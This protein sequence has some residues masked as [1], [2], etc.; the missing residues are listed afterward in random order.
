[1]DRYL[2]QLHAVDN[3]VIS[4]LGF[5]AVK[6]S[7]HYRFYRKGIIAVFL[8]LC[9]HILFHRVFCSQMYRRSSKLHLS[10]NIYTEQE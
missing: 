4:D 1:M 5:R 3:F 9:V 6:F 7:S 2:I 10:A 8:F